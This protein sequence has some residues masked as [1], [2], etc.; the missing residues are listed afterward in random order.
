M[1]ALDMQEFFRLD[2][3]VWLKQNLNSKTHRIDLI[4]WNVLFSFVVWNLWIHRNNITFKGFR[5][6]QNLWSSITHATTEYIFRVGKPSKAMT[7]EVRRVRWMR[8]SNGW[9]KLNTDGSSLGN[10]G[11]ASGSGLI[12]DANG[13]WIKGFTCNI[14]VFSSVDA[15]RW[16]LKD[17][18]S[19]CLSVNISAVEIEIDAKVVFEWITN[20][21]RTN[22]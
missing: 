21:N 18:L 22:L 16:A 20:G 9:V 6:N 4:P 8:P 3:D 19:L 13:G 15:E 11:R 1:I 5:P 12:R 14:G 10:L 17:G 2:L 7:K